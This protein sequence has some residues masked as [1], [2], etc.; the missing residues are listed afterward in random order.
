MPTRPYHKDQ[1]YEYEC[2]YCHAVV[3]GVKNV[4]PRSP[5]EHCGIFWGQDGP[6]IIQ[7]GPAGAHSPDGVTSVLSLERLM[8]L[9][10]KVFEGFSA[11]IEEEE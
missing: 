3:G 11:P 8:F 6:K 1:L 4:A 9:L 5:C 7:V 10:R 2:P